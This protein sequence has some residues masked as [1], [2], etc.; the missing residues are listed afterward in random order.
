[1]AT[2]DEQSLTAATDCIDEQPL[3]AS[4][5]IEQLDQ[6]QN[7]VMTDLDELNDRIEDLLNECV[8]ANRVVL[9]EDLDKHEPENSVDD[10]PEEDA[11]TANAA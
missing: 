9:E 3:N 6:R 7:A 5:L 2:I 10:A 1:M 11:D 4:D 8:E